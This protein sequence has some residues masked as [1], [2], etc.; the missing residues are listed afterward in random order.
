MPEILEWLQRY[1]AGTVALLALAAATLYVMKLIVDKSVNNAVDRRNK[2]LELAISR[3]STFEEKILTD[4][5]T[6]IIDLT[7]RL[8]WVSANLKR[9]R[10]GHDV[11]TDFIKGKDIVPLTEIFQDLQ[12]HRLVLTERFYDLLYRRA[13]LALELANAQDSSTWEQRTTEWRQLD[14]ELRQAV[15]KE[16]NISNISWDTTTH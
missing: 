2:L 7:T 8:Q 3:R 10:A 12:I 16:F 1:S 6:K 15:D 11:P 4:R 14:D 5:Y 9:R 13:L